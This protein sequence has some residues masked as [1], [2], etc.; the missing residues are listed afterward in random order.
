MN[1]LTYLYMSIN[2]VSCHLRISTNAHISQDFECTKSH[3]SI[4]SVGFLFLYDFDDTACAESL[5]A[6]SDKFFRVLD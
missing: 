5:C 2:A 6:E 1:A 4:L 3:I